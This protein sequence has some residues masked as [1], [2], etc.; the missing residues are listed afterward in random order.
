MPSWC[1]SGAR[2]ERWQCSSSTFSSPWVALLVHWPLNHS[3][4]QTQRT[5]W[6]VPSQQLL[7]LTAQLPAHWILLSL[8]RHQ[9]SLIIPPLSHCPSPLMSIMH[10]SSREALVCW[11]LFHILFRCS[12]RGR[13]RKGR[14]TWM[15]RRKTSSRCL[16]LCFC[17]SSLLC[18]SFTSCIAVWRTHSHPICPHLLLNNFTGVSQPELR[19]LQCFG[20]HLRRVVFCLYLLF[21][22]CLLWNFCSSAVCLWWPLCLPFSCSPTTELVRAFGCVLFL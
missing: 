2:R 16:L 13:R 6:T 11:L 1:V 17:L 15:K 5:M 3:S 8:G 4:R 7:T 21:M 10:T 14:P 9:T 22:L 18:V 20:P 19:S 12:L